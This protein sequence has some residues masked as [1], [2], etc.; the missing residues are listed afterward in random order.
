MLKNAY[1]WEKTVKFV[2]AT[3]DPPPNRR[4]PPAAGGSSP[5]PPRCYSCLLLQLCR[6]CL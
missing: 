1:Y 3:G 5:R 2:S 6:V 4:L